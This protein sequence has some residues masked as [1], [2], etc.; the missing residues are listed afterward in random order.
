[1]ILHHEHAVL[2]SLMGFDGPQSVAQAWQQMAGTLPAAMRRYW[3]PFFENHPEGIL[4]SG[5]L[6]T[7]LTGFLK[8]LSPEVREKLQALVGFEDAAAQRDFFLTQ[9]HD[10]PFRTHFLDYFNNENLSKGRDPKLF[11]YARE[12]GG[13]IFYNRLLRQ[14]SLTPVK[15][16][17][18]FRFLFFG[19]AGLPEHILPPCYRKENFATLRGQLH[20]LQIVEGEAV[21]YLLSAEGAEI[22]KASLSNIFEYTS[23]EQ[24]AD[25][26]NRLLFTSERKLRFIFWNL[27]QEQGAALPAEGWN[28]V[29]LS[30]MPLPP[31]GCFYLTNA[32]LMENFPVLLEVHS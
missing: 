11:T 21:D 29:K 28:N 14:I 31:E 26:C 30:G 24:F 8:T 23:Q 19:P 25:V 2:R 27:L 12:S 32:R 18:F 10:G 6:E 13:Q 9:L 16:N 4:T 1:M 20:K 5:R 22:N 7:Y 17:F 15:D 3:N